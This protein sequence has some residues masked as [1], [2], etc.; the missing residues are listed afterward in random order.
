MTAP[1]PI[2]RRP[3]A[4]LLALALLAL[5]V[6]AAYAGRSGPEAA[7]ARHMIPHHAQAVEMARLLEARTSDPN[8]QTLARDIYLTQEAQIGQMRA[9][10]PPWER[11]FSRSARFDPAVLAAMG[12]AREAEVADL[13]SKR[14]R[15][16]EVRFLQLMIRHHQGAV[17]MITQAL[18]EVQREL[19][20]NLLLAMAK[21][22]T[23]EIALMEQLLAERG[24]VPLP[25]PPS[26]GHRH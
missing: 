19:P 7:F 20:R 12:M 6:W 24:G 2:P 22:Q 21:S 3:L 11:P 8:L 5:G 14:G 26:S 18:P 9:W 23:L 25:P 4:V 17:P 15:E 1:R 16:A 13:A 10:L